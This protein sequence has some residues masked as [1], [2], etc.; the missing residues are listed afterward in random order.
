MFFE[1]EF[2]EPALLSVGDGQ[3]PSDAGAEPSGHVC[4]VAVGHFPLASGAEP[5]GH[6]CGVAVGHFPLASGAEPSGHVCGDVVCVGGGR[7]SSITRITTKIAVVAS[8]CS[9]LFSSIILATATTAAATHADQP[10][11]PRPPLPL[12]LQPLC[13]FA[14]TI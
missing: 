9:W 2:V 8:S 12:P 4:G 10:L 11:L 1:L 14:N 5:S 3:V 13:F 7:C 6:V